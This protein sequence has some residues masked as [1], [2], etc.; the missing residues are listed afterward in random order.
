MPEPVELTVLFIAIAMGAVGQIAMKA[1]MNRVKTQSGGELGS[2]VKALPKVFTN[3]SVLFGIGIYLLSTVLWLWIL[4]KVPLS[5]AYP[6]ISVSYVIIIIA[7]KWA[8][9]ER[10][11]IWKIAAIALILAGVI[12]LGFS[13]PIKASPNPS[14][15]QTAIPAQAQNEEA[16]S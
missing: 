16:Q 1:G 10:I 2:I 4:S 11:D 12:A 3:L 15:R 6:C 8:F 5:F 9:K 7:G 13:E 14:D